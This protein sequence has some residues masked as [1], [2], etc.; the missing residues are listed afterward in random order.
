MKNIFR[1]IPLRWRLTLWYSVLVTIALGAFGGALY[2]T[3]SA[4]L[5]KNLDAS[6]SRVATSL[7]Y[8]IKQKQQDSRRPLRSPRRR[9]SNLLPFDIAPP[10]R[11]TLRSDTTSDEP[12]IVWTAIY[13]HMLLNTRTFVIQ[14]ADTGGT[15]LWHSTP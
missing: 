12:D 13:E 5:Y 4:S 11:D 8:V 9:R 14:I 6:I 7:D 10:P 3:V 15:I 1:R 2:G